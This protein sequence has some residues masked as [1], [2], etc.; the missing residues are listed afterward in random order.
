MTSDIHSVNYVQTY[1]KKPERYEEAQP[2][3]IRA[4]PHS[5]RLGAFLILA[6]GAARH[7]RRYR[8]TVAQD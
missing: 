3:N 1:H 6:T 2:K 7:F 5:C 4:S 8:C